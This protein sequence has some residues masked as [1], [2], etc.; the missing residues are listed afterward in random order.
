MNT[1][2]IV[3]DGKVQARLLPE[4]S[5][6]GP[7]GEWDKI[8][9]EILESDGFGVHGAASEI[10]EGESQQLRFFGPVVNR[11]LTLTSVPGPY[12]MAARALVAE[13]VEQLKDSRAG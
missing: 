10:I 11:Q 1:S 13:A 8:S 6:V 3:R 2:V 12:I 5:Y 7:T 9:F 4:T